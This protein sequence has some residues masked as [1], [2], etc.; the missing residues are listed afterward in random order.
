MKKALSKREKVLIFIIIVLSI[1]FLFCL[2]ELMSKNTSSKSTKSDN[3]T[4]ET[5]SDESSSTQ[6]IE[7]SESIKDEEKGD[8][9][10][11]SIDEYLELKKGSEKSIIFIARPTCEYCAIQEPITRYLVY[12]YGIKVNYLN[13]DEIG[14]DDQNKLSKSSD[15]FKDGVSTPTTLIV[16]NDEVV[17]AVVGLMDLEHYTKFFRD[18]GIID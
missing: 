12:K 6:A 14:A 5:D 9:N 17:D 16:Q 4:V 2:S 13:T 18:Y 10:D 15:I 3:D 8:L 1:A 11:I 7:D